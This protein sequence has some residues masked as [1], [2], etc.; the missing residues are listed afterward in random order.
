MKLQDNLISCK[1]DIINQFYS[2]I[3]GIEVN[4]C[5]KSAKHLL[6][7][8]VGGIK[9]REL[10]KYLLPVLN[11]ISLPLIYLHHITYL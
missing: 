8:I 7:C 4:L 5:N 11:C 6:K 1:N 9:N 3:T 2:C 10:T